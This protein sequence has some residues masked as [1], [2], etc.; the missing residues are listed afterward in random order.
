MRKAYVMRKLGRKIAVKKYS[1]RGVSLVEVMVAML[2]TTAGLLGFAALQT[3]ALNSTE[4]GYLRV[5]AMRMAESVMERM[6]LNGVSVTQQSNAGAPAAATVYSLDSNW[7]GSISSVESANNTTLCFYVAPPG[8]TPCSSTRMAA[9]D[10]ATVRRQIANMLPQGDIYMSMGCS[11]SQA[12]VY[13][14]WG[15]QN[16]KACATT[17]MATQTV[18]NR[19]V[20]LQGM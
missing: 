11:T 13:A 3:R 6:R 2:V 7:T 16:A 17:Y 18:P 14:S 5:Q 19:C 1:Q 4:D 9:A 8:A 20:V 15:G 12:C 10:I